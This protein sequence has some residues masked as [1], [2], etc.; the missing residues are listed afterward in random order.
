MKK[1]D[2]LEIYFIGRT[3]RTCRGEL[4]RQGKGEIRM[5]Q[6]FGLGS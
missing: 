3:N 2:D 1:K 4:E 6:I 5:S